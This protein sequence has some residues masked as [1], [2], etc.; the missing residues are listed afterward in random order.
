MS[1]KIK[2]EEDPIS[3]ED[4]FS[5]IQ[6]IID[7]LEEL[8]NTLDKNKFKAT[9]RD[10]GA[11]FYFKN[12]IDFDA[13]ENKFEFPDSIVLEKNMNLIICEHTRN[14]IRGGEGI[15]DVKEQ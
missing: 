7:Y 9:Q 15:A 3:L 8:G 14:E 13:L 2:I 10:G 6:P 5:N 12:R 4:E 11:V 1:N